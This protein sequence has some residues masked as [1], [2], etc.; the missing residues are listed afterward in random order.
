MLNIIK[1]I[2]SMARNF[3]INGDIRSEV[4]KYKYTIIL[5]DSSLCVL[6]IR[7]NSLG[8]KIQKL[9]RATLCRAWMEFSDCLKCITFQ[10]KILGSDTLKNTVHKVSS[11]PEISRKIRG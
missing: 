7:G 4:M 1:Q 8:R 5:N 11:Y 9:F 3:H 10:L 2:I 6:F